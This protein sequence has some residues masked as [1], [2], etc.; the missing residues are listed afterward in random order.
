[1]KCLVGNSF[2]TKFLVDSGANINIIPR[3]I[4]DKMRS[5]EDCFLYNVRAGC[6]KQLTAY[7][8]KPL[9]VVGT[10]KA[11]I[12]IPEARSPRSLEEFFIVE[13]SGSPLLSY[14]TA[15]RL[16]V[17]KIG[18]DI[19][20]VNLNTE[21]ATKKIF[22]SVP[23]LKVKFLIDETIRPVKNAS[24]PHSKMKSSNN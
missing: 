4:W 21:D 15:K 8:G 5:D 22:P 11:H 3:G 2:K 17:I 10:F 24:Q 20:A 16:K 23:G 9:A 1:M 6:D 13:E 18:P 19:N 12:Q 14:S 7:G